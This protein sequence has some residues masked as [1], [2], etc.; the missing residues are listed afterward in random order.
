[1]SGLLM[2][3][4]LAAQ[5]GARPFEE[6]VIAI[7]TAADSPLEVSDINVRL[8]GPIRTNEIVREMLDEMAKAGKIVSLRTEGSGSRPY[9]YL[10]PGRGGDAVDASNADSCGITAKR[11]KAMLPM[12]HAAGEEGARRRDIWK[13]FPDLNE[14]QLDAAIRWLLQNELALKNEDRRI[15]AAPA[16]R[17]NIDI[18]FEAISSHE[19]GLLRRELIAA[20]PDL[21]D[22]KVDGAVQY[23]IN[24]GRVQRL[25]SRHLVAVP[26]EA[27]AA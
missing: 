23:L 21:N 24:I 19:G 10:L 2:Q 14:N 16:K 8:C 27:M 20:V 25:P 9:V 4:L 22:G 12:I 13:A 5:A 7:L 3:Q 18:V 17:L 11:A 15:V 1:M 6:Q 26:V